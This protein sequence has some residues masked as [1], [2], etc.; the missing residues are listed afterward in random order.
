MG[1]LYKL[2]GVRPTTI[3]EFVDL[4]KRE[5]AREVVVDLV[6]NPES[7]GGML[8]FGIARPVNMI[9]VYSAKSLFG[10]K[11]SFSKKY[12]KLRL[13]DNP[14]RVELEALARISQDRVKFA[15]IATRIGGLGESDIQ[16]LYQAAKK[17]NI[18]I[19]T[20]GPTKA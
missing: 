17:Y 20:L 13:D 8:K 1:K 19:G 18:N 12:A 11:I 9:G 7:Y 16:Q 6:S 3:D 2:F 4:C 15:G 10:K 14:A 5:S